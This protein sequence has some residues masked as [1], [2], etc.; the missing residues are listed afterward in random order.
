[1]NDGSFGTTAGVG[2]LDPE[3]VQAVEQH[4]FPP[5]KQL[6]WRNAELD[7]R[8]L[9]GL[10]QSLDRPS[11]S[12]LLARTRPADDLISLQ[13]L[14]RD[15]ECA[16]MAVAPAAIKRLWEVCQIPDFRKNLAENHHRLL[17]Q[18]Y[19][20]LM[21][22]S[23]VLPT[24][25]VAEHVARL[26]RS[27]GDIDT[28]ATRIAHTRTWT[29][30]SH[31]D[32]W[33]ADAGH[34]QERAR[35]IEDKLSDALHVALTSRF[36]DRRTAVLLRRLKDRESLF[37][38][39]TAEGEVLVEGQFVGRL[40]G[41]SFT[42]DVADPGSEARAIRTA[43][44]RVLARELAN[45]AARLAAAGDAEI[46]WK[47]DNRF[48]WDGAP[49]AR[50]AR[51][52]EAWRPA[53]VALP[54]EH[55]SGPLR[56]RVRRRLADWIE[57]EIAGLLRPLEA[58]REAALE[59]AARGI[60]YQVMEGLG[61]LPRA[62]VD[63]LIASL[64]KSDRARLKRLGLRLGFVDVF[65]PALLKPDRIAVRARLWAVAEG[66][67]WLPA[68]P[69]GVVSAPAEPEWPEGFAAACGYRVIGARAY[70]V[71]ML[72]RLASQLR[73]AARSGPFEV[74]PAMLSLLGSSREEMPAVLAALGYRA[75]SRE[76]VKLYRFAGRSAEP[77]PWARRGVGGSPFAPLGR[78]KT[79]G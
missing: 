15:P 65:L 8:S 33:L 2:P 22:P 32:H 79:G 10:L 13:A 21:A 42:P 40:R 3:T 61:S 26:D 14:A 6:Q 39:V 1:M 56:E 18:I 38:A 20:H 74:D 63:R 47:E 50:L 58:L 72:D 17:T 60:A 64:D 52:A 25:W 45:R 75:E 62:R 5:V 29:Y 30:I 46:E 24:D 71:D 27:D 55:V 76:D 51:G 77:K 66:L 67:N 4:R 11:E 23:G 53:V 49:V 59:G 7:Y 48:W 44:N 19:C 54:V 35:E 9:N 41:L 68:P 16:R 78:I 70:R 28:L 31:R 12:S 73:G 43:A 36:V 57:A 69:P 37:A 34:W